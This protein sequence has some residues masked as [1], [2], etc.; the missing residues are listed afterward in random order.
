MQGSILARTGKN[1]GNNPLTGGE[2]SPRRRWHWVLLGLVLAAFG[3]WLVNQRF[4][5]SGFHW[6]LFAASFLQLRWNW[7]LASIALALLTYYGRALRWAVMLRPLRPDASLGGLV[8]ATAIG[9]T[10]V[11]L[12][13][14]PGEFVRPYLIATR[15]RVPLSSQLA[16]WFLERMLDLL[17]VLL[18]F[19][20][21]LTQLP[22]AHA[23]LGR[24]L[25]W[26]LEVGGYLL[27]AMGALCLVILIMLG[28]FPEATR[29]RL[30]AALAGL[31]ARYQERIER[32]V[33][34]FLGGTVSTQSRR[35]VFW[36][37]FYT[38]VE[39][40]LVVLSLWCLFRGFPATAAFGLRD[41]MIFMGF[42]AFGGVLQIPG[43]GGG[44]QMVAMIVLTE[45]YRLPLE[46]ATSM[47]IVIWFI[48]FVAIVPI[49]LLLACHE[50][51]NWRRLRHLNTEIET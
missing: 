36:L 15:E 30:L 50:G 21:A 45:M 32:T 4:E 22:G 44:V 24:G 38:L 10:A 33:T 43:V 14:R 16:A 19:G 8:R 46:L 25:Q 26:V 40:A 49:G 3:A 17:A 23:S 9:F 5:Q 31:P 13:G 1:G 35:S 48:T 18:I 42:I 34:A 37:L 28:R 51:V 12:L 29:R 20:L 27:G 47:A 11:V 6:K 2:D 7:A 41:V 39:W